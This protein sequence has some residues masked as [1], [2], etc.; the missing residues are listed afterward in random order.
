MTG[1]NKINE[2]TN[3]VALKS[4]AWSATTKKFVSPAIQDFVW[5]NDRIMT[6]KCKY[7]PRHNPP[8]PTCSCGMYATYDF[9]IAKIYNRIS[10]LNILLLVEACG[11]TVMHELGF[12]SE[13]MRAVAAIDA[14]TLS[15]PTLA[16]YQASDFF[17]IPLLPFQAAIRVMNTMNC[18]SL[19]YYRE[20][21][22]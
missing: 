10:K 12:R 8:E 17:G 9:D 22:C 13:E 16:A 21:E 18:Y 7:D 15:Y 6:A 3:P 14:N 2:I 11:K 4:I 5:E 20:R 1:T 19:P